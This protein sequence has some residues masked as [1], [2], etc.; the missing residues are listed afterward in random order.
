MTGELLRVRGRTENLPERFSG[1][2]KRRCFLMLLLK[3]TAGRIKV[4]PE[5]LNSLLPWLIRAG[6][7]A[8][9]AFPASTTMCWQRLDA[10]VD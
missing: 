4:A 5:I 1:P 2:E 10:A 7:F 9:R 3:S 8:C 6:R